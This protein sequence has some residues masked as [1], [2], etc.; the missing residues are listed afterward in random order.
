MNP[1]TPN[2]RTI[3]LIQLVKELGAAIEK[4]AQL[5]QMPATLHIDGVQLPRNSII[6]MLKQ[7]VCMRA[8]EINH[9]SKTWDKN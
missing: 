7:D 2:K 1:T 8:V 5:E 9:L 3:E 4:I 6:K